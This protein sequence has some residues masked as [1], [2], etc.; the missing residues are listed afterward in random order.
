[1]VN[2]ERGARKHL[3]LEFFTD[4]ISAFVALGILDA[5]YLSRDLDDVVLQEQIYEHIDDRHDDQEGCGFAAHHDIL[6]GVDH[7]LHEVH[8]E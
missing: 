7:E 6:I 1:M 8:C 3:V 2:D 5:L 4:L